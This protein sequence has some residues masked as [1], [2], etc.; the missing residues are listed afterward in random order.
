MAMD[1]RELAELRRFAD[2]WACQ[3][4]HEKYWYGEAKRDVDLI[5]SVFTADARYS[6]ATG[7]AEIREKVAG[8]MSMMGPV[9]ENYHII[10]IAVDI[11]VNGDRAEGEIRGVGF[12]RIRDANGGEKVLAVGI[13]YL[14]EFVRTPEGWRIS[15][16]RG[17]EG[18]FEVP[19]DTTW[20]FEADTKVKG[21]SIL[22]D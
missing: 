16:M 9:V 21:L 11:A 12:V 2:Q 20:Q 17:I 1:E 18:G 15:A 4:L 5:C 14:D 7:M 22:H 13:G 8:Y 6:T 3:K 19:H 10:P